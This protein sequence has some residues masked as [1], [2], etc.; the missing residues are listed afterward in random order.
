VLGY[1]G[2]ELILIDATERRS[3]LEAATETIQ[4]DI[5]IEQVRLRILRCVGEQRR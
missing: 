4:L 3:D 5:T 1:Q 2:D